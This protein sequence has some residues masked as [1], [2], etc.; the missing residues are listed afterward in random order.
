MKTIALAKHHRN[1]QKYQSPKDP[2]YHLILQQLNRTIDLAL[3][4]K[5]GQPQGMKHLPV[6]LA[7]PNHIDTDPYLRIPDENG[8]SRSSL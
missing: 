2:A 7:K 1:I 5:K 3:L 6:A 8:I 4:P